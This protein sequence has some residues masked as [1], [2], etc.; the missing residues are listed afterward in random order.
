MRRAALRPQIRLADRY[1]FLGKIGEGTYGLVYKA[2]SLNEG[3]D[4]KEYAIK[5]VKSHKEGKNEVVLSMATL[6]EIKLLRELKHD[7]IV[8]LHDVHVDPT[9]H[10][11]A[12]VFEYAHHDLRDIIVQS[13][14]R[15]QKLT[16]YTKKSLMYQILKGMKY[17]HDNWILHRDMKPQNILVVGQGRKRGQVKIADFGLARIYQSPIKALTEVE[18]VVVTLWYRAPELLLGA[19]HYTRAVD[20]WSLGCIFAGTV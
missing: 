15:K 11:L 9:E 12:L 16:E 4:I 6:R 18:R 17:L 1:N 5:M 10:S 20:I 2:K 13:A 14:Q 7:N 8:Y 3:D 19:K